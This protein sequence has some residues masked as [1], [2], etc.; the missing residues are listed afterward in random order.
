MDQRRRDQCWPKKGNIK[1]DSERNYDK[2]RLN[3]MI[4]EYYFLVIFLMFFIV[5]FFFL[6]FII[7]L[8]TLMKIIKLKINVDVFVNSNVIVIRK[9]L[10]TYF[11]LY[12]I[13][14]HVFMFI[15]IQ[16]WFPNFFRFTSA[17]YPRVLCQILTKFYTLQIIE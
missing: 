14:C 17:K 3:G 2:E 4:I 15:L 10:H 11:V 6:M 1:M 12:N 9:W 13:I 7:L 5:F 8:E 16:F